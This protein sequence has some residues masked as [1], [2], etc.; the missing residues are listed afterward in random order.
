MTS[1]QAPRILSGYHVCVAGQIRDVEDDDLLRL[2]SLC[3]A[4]LVPLPDLLRR[5]SS[6][7]VQRNTVMVYDGVFSAMT[8][9]DA[10][11]LFLFFFWFADDF[12]T[13]PAEQI[14][15]SGLVP[16]VKIHWLYDSIVDYKVQPLDEYTDQG[17]AAEDA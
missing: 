7:S 10:F 2:V 4:E 15:R 9:L 8:R 1:S 16:V 12:P 5:T 17:D 11:I 13:T 14:S 3:G 6:D